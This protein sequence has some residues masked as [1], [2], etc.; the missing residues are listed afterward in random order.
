MFLLAIAELQIQL[1]LKT[2][3][4][5]DNKTMHLVQRRKAGLPVSYGRDTCTSII[6]FLSTR[7]I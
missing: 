1:L 4:D 2:S 5:K 6:S 3:V 7:K